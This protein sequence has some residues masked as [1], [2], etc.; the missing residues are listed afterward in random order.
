[1]A[2][3]YAK[4]SEMATKNARV[5][6]MMKSGGVPAG[7]HADEAADRQLFKSMMREHMNKVPGKKAA[8]RFARGGKV[9]EGS[10]TNIIVVPPRST[11]PAAAGPQA[12]GP[13]PPP[14]PPA[15][16]PPAPPMGPM[17]PGGPGGAMPPMPMRARGGKVKGGD[18]SAGN[19]TKWSGRARANSYARG[20]RLPT[21]G[22]ETGEGRLQ[23]A[24]RK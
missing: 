4:H 15:S 6:R 10:N 20:G 11:S 14:M 1:M 9:K 8:G 12:G 7:G 21:A 18:A 3:P 16:G 2:H 22:A 13:P 17:G 19:L 24:H 5:H 23:K